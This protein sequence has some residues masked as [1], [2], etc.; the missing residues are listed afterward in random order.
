MPLRCRGFP[1]V[2]RA[3]QVP[4]TRCCGCVDAALTLG[5]GRAFGPK[6]LFAGRCDV[7]QRQAPHAGG[8]R[9]APAISKPFANAANFPKRKQFPEIPCGSG[10]L[11]KVI[12]RRVGS[13]AISMELGGAGGTKQSAEGRSLGRE[14]GGEA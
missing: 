9:G 12:G 14:T 10:R 4:K 8:C 6:K 13:A 3:P 7:A 1:G 2:L 11:K 5:W